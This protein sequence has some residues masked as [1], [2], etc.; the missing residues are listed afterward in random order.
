MASGPLVGGG[1]GGDGSREKQRWTES[2]KVYTRKSHNK[3]PKPA[4][5]PHPPPSSDQTPT[6]ATAADD[7]ASSPLHPPPPQPPAP[8]SVASDDDASSL[9]RPQP[10]DAAQRSQPNGHSRSVTISLASRSRQEIRE[11]RR[12]LTAE[13]EQVRALSRKIE[14]R[15]VQIAAAAAAASSAP[16]AGYTHSQLSVTDPNTP[17][18][19]KT[20]VSAPFRRQPTVSV[21]T[22]NN[23]SEGLEKEKRTPKANQYYRNSDFV[24]GKEKFPPPEPHGHKKSKVNGSKKHSLG[25]LDHAGEKKLYAQAFKSCAA[26]LSKLMKHKHGWVFN[27]PVD[28][29]ALG[30]HDYFSIIKHPMDLGTVKSRLSKNWYKSPRE[31]A[32]DVRLTFRNAMIYNPEGQDVHI[33]AKQLSQMFEERWPAIEAEFAYHS[34]TPAPKKPLPLDMRTLERSDSTIYPMAVDSKTKP[35]NYAPHIGRPQALKKPKAKDPHKR[36]MTFEEKQRLSNNLQNLPPEKLEN[37]VQIIKK[38][39][40]SVYQHDDEIEVDIDSVDVETLWELDRFV[41]NY[42]KSLSKNKR[43]AELAVLARQEAERNAREMVHERAQKPIPVEM[44]NEMADEKYVASS[45]PAAEETKGDNAS[46]SSS[47]SSSS[48]DSGSSST[49]SDSDSSSA[50]GSDVARSP[51]T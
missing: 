12:K 46:R 7:A 28:V 31:F 20:P 5:N 16:A 42:K 35:V 38:R 23:P 33:M 4:S 44:P 24:L 13:L 30:L 41:T 32:E 11:L 45:S 19:T 25:E 27:S 15:E 37:I 40:S 9:N 14:A 29:K 22:E 2:N 34:H 39:N 3:N 43:K 6:A 50:Y 51:R 1:T 17:V 48:S 36:D 26:L 10:P 47:S 18:S 21:A 49:D 8:S